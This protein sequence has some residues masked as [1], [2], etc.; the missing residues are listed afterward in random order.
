MSQEIVTIT[1]FLFP[2]ISRFEIIIL[3]NFNKKYFNSCEIG[4]FKGI[5]IFWTTAISEIAVI[6]IWENN[7][8]SEI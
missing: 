3:V 8:I 5:K 6:H 1:K 7:V 2:N 4:Y